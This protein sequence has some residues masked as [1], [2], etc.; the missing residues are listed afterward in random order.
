MPG[1]LAVHLVPVHIRD[2]VLGGPRVL[3]SLRSKRDLNIQL[4]LPNRVL[5]KISGTPT[6]VRCFFYCNYFRIHSFQSSMYGTLQI[7]IGPLKFCFWSSERV[8]KFFFGPHTFLCQ[9]YPCSVLPYSSSYRRAF[10]YVV[11]QNLPFWQYFQDCTLYSDNYF[12]S[13]NSFSSC[14]W[15]SHH[16]P[17]AQRNQQ[18]VSVLPS[19]FFLPPW[20]SSMSSHRAYPPSHI[21][22]CW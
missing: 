12:I 17:S 1:Q 9:R 10:K 15:V 6:N 4:K 21:S 20:H 19:R 2:S 14:S 22:R 3:Y 18:I 16:L 8:L 5:F 7:L 13:H 11:S